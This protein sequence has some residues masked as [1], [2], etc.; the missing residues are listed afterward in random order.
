MRINHIVKYNLE[1]SARELK[2]QDKTFEEI[3][4]ILSKNSNQKITTS[5]VFRYFKSNEFAINQVI[6][7]KE[8]LQVKVTKAEILTIE[9][10][11]KRLDFLADRI[12]ESEDLHEISYATKVYNE[13]VDSLAKELGRLTNIG[14]NIDNSKTEN[15]VNVVLH[16]PRK[17]PYP[18]ISC[19]QK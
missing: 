5:C 9:R 2:S 6:E 15:S 11:I 7:T 18:G 10:R 17:N 1:S 4:S 19:Q 3:A 8:K 13:L 16:L 14:I 12:D